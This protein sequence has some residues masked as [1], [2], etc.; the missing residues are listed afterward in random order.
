MTN[1][2]LADH[3]STSSWLSGAS[4]GSSA[5]A[6]FGSLHFLA[7]RWNVRMLVSGRALLP[8]GLQLLRFAAVAAVLT[9][10]AR[11]FG[12]LPL[13]AAALG[14]LVARIIVLRWEMRHD[15]ISAHRQGRV[16]GRPGRGHRARRGD[17]G[18]DGCACALRMA[19]H[20]HIVAEAVQAADRARTDRRRRSRTRS[21]Q[22]CGSRRSPIFR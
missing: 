14:L 18:T 13:L 6:L 4:A 12:A 9:L 19:R 20:A 22:Q 2:W 3:A 21:E 16:H 15:P 11:T 7:L 8:V 10:V 1:S 17:L 5:G